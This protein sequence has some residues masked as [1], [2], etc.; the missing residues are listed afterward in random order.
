MA[1]FFINR[2]VFGCSG[3][4][5]TPPASHPYDIPVIYSRR[6]ASHNQ[7]RGRGAECAENSGNG[8]NAHSYGPWHLLYSPV[9]CSGD[10]D[11]CP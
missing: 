10:A 2:P 7:L 6:C 5:E 1:A 9:L 8:G 3:C 11:I 4:G